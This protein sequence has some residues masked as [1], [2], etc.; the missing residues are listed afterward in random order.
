MIKKN[1]VDDRYAA[2]VGASVINHKIE[3]AKNRVNELNN[4]SLDRM[5]E[6]KIKKGQRRWEESEDN[7]RY[8]VDGQLISY[9][10]YKT[11][12]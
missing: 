5:S 8:R 11:K 6:R 7:S 9:V 12:K 4:M 1:S 10:P 2:Y 3:R